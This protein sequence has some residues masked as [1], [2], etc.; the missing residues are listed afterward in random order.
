MRQKW[1]VLAGVV[2]WLLGA[3]WVTRALVLMML[4]G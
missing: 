1:W 2:L 4:P 3:A